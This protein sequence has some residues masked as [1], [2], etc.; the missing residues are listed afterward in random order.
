[1][2]KKGRRVPH[3]GHIRAREVAH[4][5]QR[6]LELMDRG[7]KNR[8]SA[9]VPSG[10]ATDSEPCLAAVQGLHKRRKFFR[11]HCAVLSVLRASPG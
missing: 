5:S 1:M 10:F 8:G 2:P 6:D 7:V 9:H 4:L 3:D 11:Q